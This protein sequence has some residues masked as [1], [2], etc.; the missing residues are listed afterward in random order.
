MPR[1]AISDAEER[2][3][4]EA[5]KR[6]TL[7]VNLEPC[8]HHGKT[9]PCTH[10]IV[11]KGVPRVVVGTIDPFPQAQGRGIR[12]LRENGVDVEVGVREDV[13]RRFNE[14]FFHHVETG[15]P[16]VTLKMAQ[17]LDGRVAP[18]WDAHYLEREW[19]EWLGENEIAPKHPER[20]LVKFCQTWFEKRGR[21]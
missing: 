17:T 2:H 8:S 21:P 12:Q 15:R 6:A 19:R 10:L 11:E 9:P 1:H 14:A 13:C 18:G 20:H 16:L 4:A 7:Y 5:L 3:G